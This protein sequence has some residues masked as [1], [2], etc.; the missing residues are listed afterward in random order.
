M[1]VE[2]V[3]RPPHDE[4]PRQNV[5]EDPPD[6]GCHGVRLRCPEVYVE[7]DDRHAYTEKVFY[8]KVWLNQCDLVVMGGDSCFKD[9]EFEFQHCILYGHV[10]FL[11]FVRIVMFV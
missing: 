5:D 7:H 9:R 4:Q 3:E 1:L 8:L 11:F 6:P 10:S 2:I